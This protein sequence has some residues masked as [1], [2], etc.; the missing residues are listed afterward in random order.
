MV[1]AASPFARSRLGS[2]TAAVLNSHVAPTA[3]FVTNGDA[4]LEAQA[5]QRTLSEAVGKTVDFVDAMRLA[6]RLTGDAIAS[7]LLMLGY[8]FQRGLVPLS[9]AAIE[10]AIEL[11]GVAVAANKR[12]LALGRLATHDC[13]SIGRMVGAPPAP[14]TAEPHLDE[15]VER[16][17]RDL[18]A[19]QDEAYAARYRRLIAAVAAAELTQLKGR[20]DLAKAAAS[21]LFKLMAYKDEYEV[22]RLFT[23]GDFL[24]KLRQ[25][26][27]GKL[28]LGFH[29]APPLSAQRDPAT[30]ELKKR[31]F[32]P[33]VFSLFKLLAR[34]KRLRGTAFDVFGYT[35]ER[36]VERRLVEE[37][38]ATLRRLID[39]L[40]PANHAVA[41]EIARLPLKIRGYGHV[42]ER[43]LVSVRAEEARLFAAF[44][45]PVQSAAAE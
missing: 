10:R 33:W 36:R 13:G 9:L 19:Y 34:M 40:S 22:A 23:D 44:D 14:A 27:E 6:T 12:A 1:V 39:R 8:A 32:G 7:N 28:R 35:A 24:A 2:V 38:E 15:L 41:V 26:F 25:Q 18:V 5:L 42:K 20:E 43:N 21:S 11:N 31:E 30:G 16:R 37:Y 29:L 45:H 3:A 17:A 4:D